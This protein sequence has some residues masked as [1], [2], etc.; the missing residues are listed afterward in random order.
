MSWVAGRAIESTR[1]E[2]SASASD[3]PDTRR[4]HT[5]ACISGH[6]EPEHPASKPPSDSDGTAATAAQKGTGKQGR[7]TVGL[8]D[9]R[10]LVGRPRSGGAPFP[11]DSSVG[12]SDRGCGGGQCLVP[13]GVRRRRRRR[14]RAFSV[15]VMIASRSCARVFPALP[16]QDVLL[17]QGVDGF[18]CGVVAAGADLPVEPIRPLFFGVRTKALERNWLS[19]SECTTVPAGSRRVIALRNADTA[20]EAFILESME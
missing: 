8:G 11:V 4:R 16:V 14:R 20:S 7:R 5:V 17:Q 18:H 15:Q 9:Q 2:I 6:S 12:W 1:G 19:P 13:T 10:R 3:S